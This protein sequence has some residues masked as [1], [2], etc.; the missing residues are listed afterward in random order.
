[1]KTAAPLASAL[2]AALAASLAALSSC[3]ARVDATIAPAGSA[4]IE[5]A[6]EI[7]PLLAT[8][9][10]A[11]GELEETSPLFDVP[12]IRKSFAKRSGIVVK[13]LSMPGPD[14][15]RL[16]IELPD[17][18]SSLAS[19]DI[20]RP[21]LLRLVTAKGESELILRLESGK[22]EALAALVPGIDR[23]LLDALAP[24]ALETEGLNKR[25]YRMALSSILGEKTLPALDSASVDFELNVP[26][27]VLSTT[28][29]R[30][31]GRS[32]KFSIP[33][34][35]LLVLERPIEF[36]IKWKP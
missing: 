14:S 28:G 11:F 30:L 34:L 31:D 36:R 23:D 13:S 5:V 29:G 15:L 33:L 10:R 21:G 12:G 32:W 16:S 27:T 17:L 24:P 26:G 2:V 8:R 7:P 9:L 20:A 3:S 25:E 18:A 1:M 4:T 22:G 6:A 35:D 19:P